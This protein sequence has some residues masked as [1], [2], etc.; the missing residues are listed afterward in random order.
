ML[1]C[2]L[3]RRSRRGSCTLVDDNRNKKTIVV[4]LIDKQTAETSLLQTPTNTATVVPPVSQQGCT[5]QPL[6]PVKAE[7]VYQDTQDRVC[8]VNGLCER[9]FRAEE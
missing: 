4:Q 2:C 7:A 3:R 5:V 8:I 9:I 6:S 1:Y